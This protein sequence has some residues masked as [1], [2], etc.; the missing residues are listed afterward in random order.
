[1]LSEAFT[2]HIKILGSNMHTCMHIHPLSRATLSG[3]MKKTAHRHVDRLIPVS[4]CFSRPVYWSVMD[5][6]TMKKRSLVLACLCSWQTGIQYMYLLSKFISSEFHT[7][8]SCSL[9]KF[10]QSYVLLEKA[11]IHFFKVKSINRYRTFW[12]RFQKMI[13]DL[14]GF[15][16]FIAI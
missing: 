14:W 8:S 11:I 15:I 7:P 10:S 12:V 3:M 5:G 13:H 16:T 4:A 2:R 6:Q 9:N 1:M